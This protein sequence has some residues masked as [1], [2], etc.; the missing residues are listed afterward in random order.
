MAE[1]LMP[2]A[3]KAKTLPAFAFCL[4]SKPLSPPCAA[5][6]GASASEAASKTPAAGSA[7][8]AA[9][10]RSA[11]AETSEAAEATR[12]AGTAEVTGAAGRHVHMRAVNM[13]PAEN[14]RVVYDRRNDYAR[15]V[16]NPSVSS[17]SKIV[18]YNHEEDNAAY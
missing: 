2:V 8:E 1:K 12:S 13:P 6:P 9:S 17:V 7:S 11:A 15:A 4:K 14:K 3:K 18:N 5:A 16:I 10:A